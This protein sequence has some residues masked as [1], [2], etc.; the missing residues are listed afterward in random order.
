MD[1]NGLL[2]QAMPATKVGDAVDDSVSVSTKTTSNLAWAMHV[3][4]MLHE[5]AD[6]KPIT[7][8]PS[9]RI[10]LSDQPLM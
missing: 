9:R 2:A 10:A 3:L 8:Q 4:F 6:S 5:K 7:R 1:R